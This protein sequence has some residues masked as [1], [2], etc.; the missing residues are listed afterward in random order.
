[1]YNVLF[2]C[3]GNSARS[4]IG[5]ALVERWGLGHFAGYSAGSHPKGAIHPMALQALAEADV[6]AI[7]LSSKHWNVF[8]GPEAPHMDFVITVCDQAAGEACP[9]W[10]GHPITAYWGLPDPAIVEG[11]AKTR[12]QAFNETLR[13]LEVR[14]QML[15]ALRMNEADRQHLEERL[16]VIGGYYPSLSEREAMLQSPV[17][18]RAVPGSR[19]W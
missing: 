16:T 1:M 6:P 19:K 13:V 7:G 9:V 4:I 3:T 15:V 5:E 14:I 18:L 12:R 11:C 8:S 10:P 17:S 2:L